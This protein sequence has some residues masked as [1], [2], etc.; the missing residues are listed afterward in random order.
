MLVSALLAVSLAALDGVTVLPCVDELTVRAA[1][2][3]SAARVG[4]IRRGTSLKVLETTNVDESFSLTV[5]RNVPA[6]IKFEPSDVW[7]KVA[8]ATDGGVASGWVYGGLVCRPTL[9][10]SD[11][12]LSVVG[13]SQDS[14]RLAFIERAP[15]SFA[16]GWGRPSVLRIVEV[17]SGKELFALKDDCPPA[18][19]LI[20]HRAELTVA[21]RA[22][23]IHFAWF[24]GLDPK[25][26]GVALEG[27]R[28]KVLGNGVTRAELPVD[29]AVQAIDDSGGFPKAQLIAVLKRPGVDV[30]MVRVQAS[31]ENHR[32]AARALRD[33]VKDAWRD[34]LPGVRLT[35]APLG[36]CDG[37]LQGTAS[38][39]KASKALE[40]LTAELRRRLEKK[41]RKL[42]PDEFCLAGAGQSAK[43]LALTFVPQQC[44][45][46]ECPDDACKAALE[47]T[48]SRGFGVLSEKS[49]KF[50]G[51]TCD[52]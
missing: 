34:V 27:R 42:L 46:N 26:L 41:Y 30:A 35:G 40:G 32:Y 1:P 14:A 11:G 51:Y 48:V 43:G 19:L 22:H 36:R 25:P 49:V 21:L 38:D 47:F 28:V 33:E 12:Q 10:A 6:P 4:V 50:D 23:G 8:L 13:W 17:A 5:D 7:L 18:D 31:E 3:L 52:P 9:T 2:S 24:I 20:S 29:F 44:H 15:D 37:M 45:G 39:V 16:C